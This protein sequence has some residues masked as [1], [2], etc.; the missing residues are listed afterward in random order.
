MCVYHSFFI[1]SSLDGLIV[2]F[3]VLVIVHS[4]AVNPGAH[5]LRICFSNEFPG[6]ADTSG[7]KATLIIVDNI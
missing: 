1:L 2:W 6:D 4:A 3:R 7:P 5:V